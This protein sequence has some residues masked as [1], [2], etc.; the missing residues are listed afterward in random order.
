MKPVIVSSTDQGAPAIRGEDGSL[1]TLL[2]WAL[3]QLGWTVEH[4]D[5]ATYRAAFRGNPA[6]G[7]GYLLRIRDRA[8]DHSSDSRYAA[9]DAFSGMVDID[10]GDDHFPSVDRYWLKSH[11]ADDATPHPWMIIGDDRFFWYL[12]D[13]KGQGVRGFWAGDYIPFGLNDTANFCLGTTNP[14]TAGSGSSAALRQVAPQSESGSEIYQCAALSVDGQRTGITQQLVALL[15]GLD[16]RAMLGESGPFPDPITGS[17]NT[18][19]IELHDPEVDTRRGLLPGIL[20]PMA[21]LR[22]GAQSMWNHGDVVSGISNG[23]MLTD[24]LYVQ[25][26][27]GLDLDHYGWRGAAFFDITHEWSWDW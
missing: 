20:N 2:K 8:A 15:G 3:P 24:M 17:V 26:N 19:R 4:D 10:T 12:P 18:S 22:R 13:I 27:R 5:A 6:R 23:R 21:N 7:T 14:N 11:A 16:S 25:M 1:Y 9:M